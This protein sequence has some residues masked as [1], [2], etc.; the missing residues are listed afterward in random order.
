MV[1]KGY[2]LG[3]GHAPWLMQSELFPLNIRGRASGVATAT[4]WFMNSCVVI[5]FLP[6]TETITISGTFW[7]YA[8]LM[9][10]GWFFVYFMVPETSGRSLEEITEDF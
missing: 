8:L 2:A 10:F 6:L 7:L 3:L 1:D 5:A 4:N 9:T